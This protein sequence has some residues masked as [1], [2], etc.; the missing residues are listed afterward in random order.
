MTKRVTISGASQ[1]RQRRC[2]VYTRK[3]TE[4]GLDQAFNSLDAQREA[5]EAYIK[6]QKFDAQA[7]EAL[8]E[9]PL[10]ITTKTSMR[11]IQQEQVSQHMVVL[12]IQ[13]ALKRAG[14]EMRFIIDGA[15]SEARSKPDLSMH[16]LLAQAYR[17]RTLLLNHDRRTLKEIAADV[18]VCGSY[19]VKVARMSFLAPDILEAILRDEHPLELTA[20]RIS[21]D[22]ELPVAWADQKSL[23]GIRR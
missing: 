18:G 19:F 12:T 8:L 2:A 23:M 11:A 14:M 1:L 21:R 16:R 15:D 17:Y 6:S 22:M 9:N 10:N 4:E 3:S 20:K 7:L 5:C 13:T